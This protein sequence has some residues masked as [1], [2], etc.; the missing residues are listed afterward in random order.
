M[1]TIRTDLTK[2]DLN[3]T[4]RPK[5]PLDGDSGSSIRGLFAHPGS[6]QFSPVKQRAKAASDGQDSTVKDTKPKGFPR[7]F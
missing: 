5:Q 7:R 1:Q 2:A 4:W 3:K 6:G